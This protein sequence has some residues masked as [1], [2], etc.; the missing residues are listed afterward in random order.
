MPYTTSQAIA[1]LDRYLDID[2]DKKEI[3]PDTKNRGFIIELEDGIKCV[4]FVYPLVHK[5]DNTKNYFDTRDSGAYERGVAWKYANEHGYKYFCLGVNDSVEKYVDYIFSLECGESIIEKIS[6]TTDGMRNGP[7]NQ[8]II[9][10]DYVPKTQFD[11]IQNKLGIY[12]SAVRRDYLKEYLRTYDNRPYMGDEISDKVIVEAE[13][14]YQRAANII[15]KF[16]AE[17]GWEA[18]VSREDVEENRHQ[19][20]EKFSPEKLQ[21]LGD[22]ELLDTIFYTTG[23]NT[24]SLC[25]WIEMNKEC[26]MAFGSIAGGSA[27]KF[28]LFQKRETGVWTTGSPNAPQELSDEEAL[29]LGK[30]IRDALVRGTE[31]I[32]NAQLNSLAD[33]EKLDDDLKETVGSKFYDWGWFHKYYSIIYPDR[34]SSF[35]SADWQKHALRCFLIQPSE[36]YYAR[37]GQLA[38]IQNYGGLYYSQF[39]SALREK[40]S[41]II[42]FVRLGTSDSE[43]SY[44]A[45]WKKKSVVGI[46]WSAIG[47]LE[48]YTAGASLD[49]NEI[50]KRLA[51]EYYPEDARLASRKAGELVRFYDTN[52][53][54]VF[55]PMEGERLYGLVDEIGDYFYDSTSN[56]SS[57]KTGKWHLVF[58]E[59]DRMPEKGEGLRTSCI[60]IKDDKNL[61]YL[62][63]KYYYA[64]E[65][66]IEEEESDMA[67]ESK[68]KN[69]LEIE[70]NPRT[71]KI[72]PMN[73]IIYGAPGTGKTYSTA[74]YALAIVENRSV[75]KRKKSPEERKQVMKSYNELIK[76]GQVVF[77]TFHQS[78]GYEEFIQGLRPDTKSEKMSFKTVD[79]VFKQIADLA[80]NDEDNNYVIIIDEINRANIS[81]VFGEL[82]TLIEDDKRWG[83]VNETC[84]TLQSGDVF[85]VPNNLYIVGTMN[86]ADKSISLIDAALRRRFS[87]I[88]QKPEAYLV[89]DATLRR[90]LEKLNTMLAD[91]LDS[92]DL[93]I[94]H[95][96]FLNKTVDDLYTILNN[97]IIPLLY[98]YFY[99]NKKKVASVL[100]EAIEGTDIEIVDDKIGRLSVKKIES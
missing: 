55:V 4:I 38:M 3:I 49:R 94:G 10:N 74:E 65:D 76:K 47:S 41:G 95:S 8:I 27:F 29:V 25:C 9:P 85:A 35:H 46:G 54:T 1:T 81:K 90:V 58:D 28:G 13:N 11:R 70:R 75:D 40:Y 100:K 15:N 50:A 53:D 21:N 57:M 62:Y 64:S 71:I 73:V 24:E 79:G 68:L 97:S 18:P 51:E 37:S 92:S 14:E 86:S 2:S 45:E 39:I 60:Q 34:L 87:F 31:V 30:E 7:G 6:G 98:E 82:I 44:V 5:Q 22:D 67:E 78:Y 36:K 59:N 88:E 83:E 84:A 16:I 61:L 32:K 89:E 66:G 19:F 77:T 42:Q 96:Y 17:S 99:D 52:S 56:M 43:K 63:E 12:I 80:L 23:D 69:C 93:L 33:Y 26:R 91:E 20:I 72:H 48:E